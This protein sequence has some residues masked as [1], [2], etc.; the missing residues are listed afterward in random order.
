M[1]ILIF[2]GIT[3]RVVYAARVEGLGSYGLSR[4]DTCNAGFFQTFSIIGPPDGT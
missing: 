1:R 4:Y 3:R 2:D